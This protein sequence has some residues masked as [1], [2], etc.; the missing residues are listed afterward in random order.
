MFVYTS[1]VNA[2]TEKK[3]TV[4]VISLASPTPSME[5]EHSAV[6]EAD[7]A[8]EHS[9]ESN[10]SEQDESD[11]GSGGSEDDESVATKSSTKRTK[12][13]KKKNK[14]TVP[15]YSLTVENFYNPEQAVVLAEEIMS[16]IFCLF[17]EFGS[18]RL[19]KEL[20][21]CCCNFLF[22]YRYC[23]HHKPKTAESR[24]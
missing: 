8:G 12:Q 22:L 23:W 13:K 1:A 2:N 7:E 11:A 4:S 6:S 10:D 17:L 18:L 19:F 20:N 14:N 16:K 24:L 21:E 5:S 9:D 3:T 15:K